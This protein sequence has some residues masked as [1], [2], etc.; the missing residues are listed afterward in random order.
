MTR[1]L[2]IVFIGILFAILV[3]VG[4]AVFYP[5]PKY[6]AY[7]IE[8]S[9][10]VPP[11]EGSPQAVKLEAKRIDFEKQSR[12]FQK[13]SESYNRNVSIIAMGFAVLFVLLGLA[14]AKKMPIFPDALLLGSVGTLMYSIVRGFSANDDM[15]RFLVVAVS[16]FISLIIGYVKFIKPQH[17][18]KKT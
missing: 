8:L 14:L 11:K 6:P 5:Q 3:A 15:Y 16:L 1:Y 4:I 10:T 12:D 2:Y 7:P 13:I 9:P 18:G 17:S